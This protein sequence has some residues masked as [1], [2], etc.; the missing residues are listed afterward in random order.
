M[1]KVLSGGIQSSSPARK[2]F[3]SQCKP[4]LSRCIINFGLRNELVSKFNQYTLTLYF[5]C[6]SNLT[7]LITFF[8]LT[9]V[10]LLG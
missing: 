6:C 3:L 10:R 2:P 8:K 9:G 1:Y 7:P 4:I 5:F